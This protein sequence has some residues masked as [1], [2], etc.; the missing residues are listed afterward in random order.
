MRYHPLPFPS[1]LKLSLH[2]APLRQAFP[3]LSSSPPTISFS[4]L[5]FLPI[6]RSRAGQWCRWSFYLDFLPLLGAVG[7]HKEHSSYGSRMWECLELEPS[8]APC[9]SPCLLCSLGSCSVIEM[10]PW[11]I[12]ALVGGGNMLDVLIHSAP[13]SVQKACW[14]LVLFWCFFVVIGFLPSCILAKSY[15]PAALMSGSVWIMRKAGAHLYL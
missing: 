2:P 15:S 7:W 9:P 1:F 12:P 6:W 13:V 5:L 10:V 8:V 4:P 14:L 11:L 3:G